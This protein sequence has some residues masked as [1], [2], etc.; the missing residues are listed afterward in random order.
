[1]FTYKPGAL[2][3]AADE[4]FIPDVDPK[5]LEVDTDVQTRGVINDNKISRAL[6]EVAEQ[7]RH[8][9]GYPLQDMLQGCTWNGRPC[10][11]R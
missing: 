11:V 1:M 10:G 6:A 8:A 4:P 5:W 7:T 3:D 2:T 9:M